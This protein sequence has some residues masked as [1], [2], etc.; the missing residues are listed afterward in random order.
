MVFNT[1]VSEN[2]TTSRE[3]T[4]NTTYI[5][6]AENFGNGNAEAL[7]A[8]LGSA[9]VT[10]TETTRTMTTR[11]V[12]RTIPG[13]RIEMAGGFNGMRNTVAHGHACSTGF[14]AFCE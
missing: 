8:R 3:A 10:I 11:G 13:F 9:A 1:S 12:E 14:I 2:T 7:F 6:V 4:M 5:L